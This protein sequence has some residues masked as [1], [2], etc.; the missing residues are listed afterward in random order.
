[1]SE[2]L[3]VCSQHARQPLQQVVVDWGSLGLV[4]L[5]EIKVQRQVDTEDNCR[6]SVVCVVGVC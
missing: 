3:K 5:Q 1:M 4:L 2:W 6:K